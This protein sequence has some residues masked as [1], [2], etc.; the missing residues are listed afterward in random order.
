MV[1]LW[2][3]S[4]CYY[5]FRE[6]VV[7]FLIKTIIDFEIFNMGIQKILESKRKTKDEKLA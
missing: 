5:K 2:I 4:I 1:A 7:K 6:K 3:I